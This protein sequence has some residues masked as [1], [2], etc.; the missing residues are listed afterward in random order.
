MVEPLG[1]KDEQT[2]LPGGARARPPAID[3]V[4]ILEL[5]N[6]ITRSGHLTEVFR[7]DWAADIAVHQVNWVEL[8]PGGVTDWHRHDEQTDRLV[9]VGGSIKLALWDGRLGSKT[10]GASEIVRMGALRPALV[11]VPPGVWHG[12]RNE[13]GVPAGYINVIDRGYDHARPDNWRAKPGDG[14]WPDIL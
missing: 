6:V 5:G 2:V 3:G 7:A 9:A 8:N 10:Y 1:V 14:G 12:L 11:V 13:S 4:A